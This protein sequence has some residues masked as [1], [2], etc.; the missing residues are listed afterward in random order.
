MAF[1]I[2]FPVDLYLHVYDQKYQMCNYNI[3]VGLNLINL[4]KN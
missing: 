3:S 2:W 4:N 1:N